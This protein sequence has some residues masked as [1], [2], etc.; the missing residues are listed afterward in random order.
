MYVNLV[1]LPNRT[2]LAS[3][4]STGPRTGSVLRAATFNPATRS[5]TEV[6]AD[7]IGRNYH[8][9]S[10]VLLDG[11]V[12]VFGSN[13]A[14][15][16]YEMRVSV[17]EPP[18]MFRGTRPT[19]TAAPATT[20]YGAGFDLGVTGNV[21]AA[22]LTAVGSATH[23]TDTNARLVDLPITGTG[24][25]RRATVPQNSSVLPPGPYMLTVLDDTGV[26]SVAR[27]VNVR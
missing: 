1:N 22:S 12:V 21:V 23:Q 7:P 16:S 18:Y 24:T 3:N 2:V 6:A 10:L 13:P 27:M 26:P 14:D 15:G 17:F 20:T 4:G 9:A 19:I 8:S 25:T 5:W 11:R